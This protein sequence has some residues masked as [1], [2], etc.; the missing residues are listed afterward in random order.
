MI[1]F[2][3]ILTDFIYNINLIEKEFRFVPKCSPKLP[4]LQKIVQIIKCLLSAILSKA[5]SYI[6]RQI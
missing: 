2:A 4:C 6:F 1:L 3:F 5:V